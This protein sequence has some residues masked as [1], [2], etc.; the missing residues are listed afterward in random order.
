MK[1]AHPVILLLLMAPMAWVVYSWETY[2][3]QSLGRAVML[4]LKGLSLAAILFALSEP[5]MILPETKTAEVVLLDTSASITPADL[6]RASAIAREIEAHRGRNWV[7]V[8]P[9]NSAVR[10][11]RPEETA[12]GLRLQPVSDGSSDGTNLEAAL[13]SSMGAIPAGYLPRFLLVSDGNENQG[14]AVRAIAQMQRLGIP[15]DTVPLR[16][17]SDLR[18]AHRIGF[19]ARRSLQRRTD[20]HQSD[21]AIAD[22]DHCRV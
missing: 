5:S 17:Q 9:F 10:A 3:R 1:F 15:V 21:V 18:P 8:V 16:G 7:K 12:A 11:L 13:T 4:L 19:P 20:S 14:S 22:R 2:R 6:N